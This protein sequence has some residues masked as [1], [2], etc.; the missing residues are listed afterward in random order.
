MSS[1][2]HVAEWKTH[3]ITQEF[4][5]ELRRRVEGLK[6]EIVSKALD[7]DPRELAF[8]AGAIRALQDML[9]IDY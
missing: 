2:T 8:R 6:D 5:Y 3:P 1:E 9:D 4:F 7:G